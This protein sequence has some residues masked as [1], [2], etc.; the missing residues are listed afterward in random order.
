LNKDR[1]DS[2]IGKMLDREMRVRKVRV[3]A[4]SPSNRI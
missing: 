1:R 3:R 2:V 4:A